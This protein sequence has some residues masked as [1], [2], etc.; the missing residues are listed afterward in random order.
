MRDEGTLP[1]PHLPGAQPI[2]K[3]QHSLSLHLKFWLF[4]K[5][6]IFIHFRVK[7]VEKSYFLPGALIG[8]L[9]NISWLA[10]MCTLLLLRLSLEVSYW[11]PKKLSK[12]REGGDSSAEEFP[13]HEDEWFPKVKNSKKCYLKEAGTCLWSF[14]KSLH[15]GTFHCADE[16]SAFKYLQQNFYS[17]WMIEQECW[18]PVLT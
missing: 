12:A 2:W 17:S 1:P 11:N 14:Q 3:P 7:S 8:I 16:K 6:K 5:E 15:T 10:A 9:E 18:Q 13:F 4:L